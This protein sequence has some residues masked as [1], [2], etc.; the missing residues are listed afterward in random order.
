VEKANFVMH[1]CCSVPPDYLE[2][3]C[4]NQSVYEHEIY[5]CHWGA[6]IISTMQAI[7]AGDIESADCYGTSQ[8][9]VERTCEALVEQA[10]DGG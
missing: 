4:Q 3:H 5:A 10:R 7:S 8:E 2:C 1:V 6:M 9:F